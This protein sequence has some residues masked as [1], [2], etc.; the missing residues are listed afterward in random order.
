[1]SKIYIVDVDGTLCTAMRSG[2]Y[3][4]AIPYTHRIDQIN[5]L[6]DEG[7]IIKIWTARGSS[8]GL[9]WYDFTKKQLDE[10]GVK[11]HSFNI[12]KPMYDVWVDDKADWIF[13]K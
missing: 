6:Y 10:W 3:E 7:N 5:K 4:K 12:G 1:M 8:S 13:T 2:E 11:Y 9:D